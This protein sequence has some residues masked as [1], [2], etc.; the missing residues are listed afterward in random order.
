MDAEKRKKEEQTLTAMPTDIPES[1]YR[2]NRG[3]GKRANSA[4]KQWVITALGCFV[5]DL[6]HAAAFC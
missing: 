3:M 4:S 2:K 5:N 6:D 1:H